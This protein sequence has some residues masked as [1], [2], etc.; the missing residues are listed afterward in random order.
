MYGDYESILNRIVTESGIAKSDLERKIKDKQE[1]LSGL[2]SPEGAAHIVAKELGI[3]LLKK[4]PEKRLEI[5]NIVSG[6][7][8]VTFIGRVTSITQVREFT[9]KDGTK[10]RVQSAYL[11]D[12]TGSI[13][14][15]L[16]NEEIERN[17]IKL[18]DG[19][20]IKGGYVVEDNMQR[21]EIRIGKGTMTITNALL[22]TV[23]QL[24]GPSTQSSFGTPT[25]TSINLLEENQ[26]AEFRA[27]V[28]Q[29]FESDPFYS[30]C[31]TCNKSMGKEGKCAEHGE[32]EPKFSMIVSAILDDGSGNIRGVFFKEAAERLISM[33]TEEALKIADKF[34]DNTIPLKRSQDAILG[35]EYYFIGRARKNKMF[36]RLEFIVSTIRDVDVNEEAKQ[37]LKN[38]AS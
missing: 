19:V 3:E 25:K 29:L 11:A 12:D 28:V 38:V 5:K 26:N 22:P 18:G 1:E 17:A 23:D 10:G 21:P 8:N 37:I 2:V 24:K 20:Q 32:V 33:P 34:R 7:R 9:K 31:P 36:N 27:A 35:K 16:W 14:I 4:A 6:M 30:V 13:R 15:S